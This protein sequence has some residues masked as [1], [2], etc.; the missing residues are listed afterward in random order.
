MNL[1]N[2]STLLVGFALVA[3]VATAGIVALSGGGLEE[4]AAA[5]GVGIAAAI[6]IL[7][8]YKVASIKGLPHS[9]SVAVAG[10]ALGVVYTAALVYRLL[11]E[12]G[13]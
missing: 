1:Q 8:S 2:R 9:H 10:L 5:F 7:G 6:V 13:A 12:F 3:V 4:L 11:T